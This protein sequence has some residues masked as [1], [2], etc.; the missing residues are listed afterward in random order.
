MP[1]KIVKSSGHKFYR[2]RGGAWSK[3][4]SG[5]FRH[6]GTG[7]GSYSRIDSKSDGKRRATTSKYAGKYPQAYDNQTK[8]RP[9]L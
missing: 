2:R 9:Y 8:K 3:T 1:C 7:N 6:V 5:G 4:K